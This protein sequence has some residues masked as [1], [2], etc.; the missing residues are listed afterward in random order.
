MKLDEIFDLEKY[1]NKGIKGQGIKIAIFDSG[2]SDL[3]N[4][5]S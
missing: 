1:H 4:E 5:E 3:Y 2:L